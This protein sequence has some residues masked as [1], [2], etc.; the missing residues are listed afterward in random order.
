MMRAAA[1]AIAAWIAVAVP[2]AA[3]SAIH[4]SATIDT[5]AAGVRIAPEI[6]GQF[7]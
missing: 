4:A 6:Y 7:A 1:A 5:R 3:Q 2:A